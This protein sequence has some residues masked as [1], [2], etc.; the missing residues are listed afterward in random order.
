MVNKR[1]VDKGCVPARGTSA[2]AGQRAF[3][4]RVVSAERE[5]SSEVKA[6]RS[7]RSTDPAASRPSEKAGR[8]PTASLLLLTQILGAKCVRG[9][10]DTHSRTSWLCGCVPQAN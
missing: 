10:C 1:G 7:S 3:F 8:E 6:R 4:P 5:A 9:R 2:L